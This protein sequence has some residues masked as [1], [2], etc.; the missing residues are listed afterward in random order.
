MKPSAPLAAG[1]VF[2]IP[3]HANMR[4]EVHRDAIVMP[5]SGSFRGGVFVGDRCLETSLLYRDYSHLPAPT[6]V[7]SPADP[8][9]PAERSPEEVIFAGYLFRHFGHFMLESLSRLWIVESFPDVPLV[10]VWAERYPDWQSEI[11]ALL[12]VQNPAVFLTRPTQYRSVI[13]PEPG[14]VIPGT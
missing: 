1:R 10:W 6:P 3:P 14:F 2:R 12:G 13:V 11:L 5:V 9:P 4:F 7:I 8:T